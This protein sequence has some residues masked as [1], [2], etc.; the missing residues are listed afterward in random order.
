MSALWQSRAGRAKQCDDFEL[1]EMP[2]YVFERRWWRR[3]LLRAGIRAARL[4]ADARL[5]H[6]LRAKTA[7]RAGRHDFATVR[8]FGFFS[9]KFSAATLK[10]GN[11]SKGYR[12]SCHPVEGDRHRKP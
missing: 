1:R 10:S 3:W 5:D 8:T 9:H 4:T 7:R 6:A 12:S 2:G 11:L